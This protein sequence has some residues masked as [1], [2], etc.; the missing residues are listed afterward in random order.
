MRSRRRISRPG[1]V[2]PAVRQAA[3]FLLPNAVYSRCAAARIFAGRGRGRYRDSDPVPA[4]AAARK[5][6]YDSSSGQGLLHVTRPL[7]RAL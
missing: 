2:F 3:C 1:V 4:A 5:L 7:Q 6:R